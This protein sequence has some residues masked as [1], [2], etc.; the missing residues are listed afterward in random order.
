M[1]WEVQ[2]RSSETYLWV[3]TALADK[4]E[5][6]RVV[7]Y[8]TLNILW[9]PPRPFQHVKRKR[10]PLGCR[11]FGNRTRT[12]RLSWTPWSSLKP[13]NT[14]VPSLSSWKW[15]NSRQVSTRNEEC[16]S[17]V[18]P[19]HEREVSGQK[20]HILLRRAHR[21]YNAETQ[22]VGEITLK[23]KVIHHERTQ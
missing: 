21:R 19:W 9:I 5:K 7:A 20:R 22:T 18:S 16:C 4:S 14:R 10:P 12:T 1:E 3:L 2:C 6:S 11:T 13:S 17:S 15:K 23:Q 8:V